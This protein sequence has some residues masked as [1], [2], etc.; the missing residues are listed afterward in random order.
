MGQGLETGQVA[1][2]DLSL[3]ASN[4]RSERHSRKTGKRYRRYLGGC[5]LQPTGGVHETG[6]CQMSEL[7]AEIRVALL[8]F[9]RILVHLRWMVG[10]EIDRKELYGILDHIE[11][12]PKLMVDGDVAG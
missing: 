1:H 4:Y 6:R 8:A 9:H 2:I 12:L 7:P 5:S 10:E 11:V 3:F